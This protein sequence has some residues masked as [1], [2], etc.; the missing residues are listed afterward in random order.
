MKQCPRCQQTYSDDTLNFCLSDGELLTAFQQEPSSPRFD[1]SPP[2][3]VLD[4]A[5]QTNPTNWPQTPSAS[6]PAQWQAQ[7]AA[8][9]QPA[10]MYGYAPPSPNQSMA[11]ASLVLAILSVT[12]GWCCSLGLL[13][14]PAG[15]ITGWIALNQIKKDPQRYSGRGMALGGIITSGVFLGLYLLFIIIYGIA[16]IGGGLSG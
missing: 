15:L 7:P 16:I 5:R 6:P 2:T 12:V 8:N 1:D 14:A 10:G 9:F 11:I 13:L 3:M 4:Q